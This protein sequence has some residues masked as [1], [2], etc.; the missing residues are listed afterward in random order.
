[1]GRGSLLGKGLQRC[2]LRVSRWVQ[3]WEKT[4][5]TE[6]SALTCR[7]TSREHREAEEGWVGPTKAG[8]SSRGQAWL[9]SPATVDSGPSSNQRGGLAPVTAL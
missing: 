4:L 9:P 5:S 3:T 2:Y 6:P 7:E 1:M 8:P